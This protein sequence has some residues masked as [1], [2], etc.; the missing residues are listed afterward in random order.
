MA[1][2]V[3]AA[4][5]G[6]RRPGG[7]CRRR[8]RPTGRA[9][10]LAGCR[11]SRRRPRRDVGRARH[12]R[13]YGR[14]APGAGTGPV[15]LHRSAS[16]VAGTPEGLV[17]I[18]EHEHAGGFGSLPG[19]DG[20]VERVTLG[21]TAG[22]F[23][24]GRLARRCRGPGGGRGAA[25][26]QAS[27]HDVSPGSAAIARSCTARTTRA[28]R[29]MTGKVSNRSIRSGPRYAKSAAPHRVSTDRWTRW[30]RSADR[31]AV[32]ATVGT[33]GSHPTGSCSAAGRRKSRLDTSDCW[34]ASGCYRPSARAR[35]PRRSSRSP[36]RH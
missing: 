17:D 19:G 31:G 1:A 27:R 20:G 23:D 18:D 3:A 16:D 2:L 14:R 4:R 9:V 11:P 7:G 6:A 25:A 12:R 29:S 24:A 10:A 32:F 34:T 30:W 28:P 22:P 13:R 36:A 33:G 21:A 26:G 35:C 5:R 8:R 15:G